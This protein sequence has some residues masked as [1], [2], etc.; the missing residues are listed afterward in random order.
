MIVPNCQ[1][2]TLFW[3]AMRALDASPPMVRDYL[4][5]RVDVDSQNYR[6]SL[7]KSDLDLTAGDFV[8]CEHHLV[9]YEYAEA[10]A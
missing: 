1:V 3:I 9:A 5:M 10:L 2:R 6:N 4:W 7:G 8:Q